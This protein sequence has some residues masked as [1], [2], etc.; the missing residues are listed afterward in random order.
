MDANNIIQEL[1]RRFS[2]PLPE[3][4]ERRIIFWYDEDREFEDKIEEIT[5]DNA[6][7]IILDGSN[8]FE[9][10]KLLSYDDKE[11]N[12]LVYDP[13]VHN[14]IEENWLL[15]IELYSEEFRADLISIWMD[16]MGI[17][18][19]TALRKQVKKYRKYFNAKDRRAKIISQKNNINKPA[20]LHLAVM[21][22]I[23]G[24][25]TAQPN[26]IIRAVLKAGLDTDTNNIYNG[27]VNYEVKDA[28]E[29]M[30]AQGTGY[31]EEEFN[32]GNLAIHIILTALTRTMHPENLKGLDKFISSSHQA[33]CYD[34]VSEWIA[35]R[36][37]EGFYKIARFVE[38]EVNLINWR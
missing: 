11:N 21:A 2:E 28:F 32:I 35:S 31:R 3:F 13:I 17:S 22:A 8:N 6:K 5:L 12:Y 27:F 25:K 36:D 30:V 20:Q 7:V 14:D 38:K 18:S 26:A 23:C 29:A 19:T 34:F 10:K 15:D 4:Y 16:E 37:S 33:Y 24:I 1:N 9:V